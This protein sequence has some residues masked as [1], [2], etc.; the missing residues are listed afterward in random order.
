MSV[1]LNT[2]SVISAYTLN[3][4]LLN[5]IILADAAISF[6]VSVS[7]VKNSSSSNVKAIFGTSRL[8]MLVNLETPLNGFFAYGSVTNSVI[9]VVGSIFCPFPRVDPSP[10]AF[11]TS[12]GCALPAIVFLI[13]SALA[14]TT[15]SFSDN[16]F[17]LLLLLWYSNFIAAS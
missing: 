17:D 2:V 15:L 6:A 4:F 8:V 10:K 9:K 16:S 7:E 14:L 3:L 1:P 11:N 13:N 5:A 12:F